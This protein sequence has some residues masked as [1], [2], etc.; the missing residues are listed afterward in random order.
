[1]NN[2]FK[3]GDKITV[4]GTDE[5]AQYC[6]RDTT[7]GKAYTLVAVGLNSLSGAPTAKDVSFTDDAGDTITIHCTDVTLAKE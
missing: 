2:T 3:I 4:T 1:M 6:T 5:A 7:K